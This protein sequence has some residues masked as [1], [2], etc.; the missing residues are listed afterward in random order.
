MPPVTKSQN[1]LE[2][3]RK[4]GDSVEIELPENR[5]TGFRWT[6]LSSGGPVLELLDDSIEAS[7]DDVRGRGGVRRWRFRA[8]TEGISRIEIEYGRPWEKQAVDKFW[9]TVRVTN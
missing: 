9:I 4:P 8:A 3:E 2:I 6:L 1:G 5:T 7:G